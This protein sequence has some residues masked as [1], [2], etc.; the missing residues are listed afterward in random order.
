MMTDTVNPKTGQAMA[1]AL[2][3]AGAT[4]I[5]RVRAGDVQNATVRFGGGAASVWTGQATDCA[6]LPCTPLGPT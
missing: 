1:D 4:C 2:M 6:S 5:C 3:D